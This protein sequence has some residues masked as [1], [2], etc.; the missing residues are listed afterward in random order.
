MPS[1][2]KPWEVAGSATTTSATPASNPAV[3][4]QD[5]S[6]PPQ[7]PDRP[8][9]LTTFANRPT[10]SALG[11]YGAGMSSGYSPYASR[12]GSTLGGYGSTYG[13]YG[14]TYSSP[15]SRFGGG[16]GSTLG[17]YGGMSGYG[18][19]GGMGGGMYGMGGGMYGGMGGIP[20][21]PN[22]PGG[23]ISLT[24]RMESGTAA[25]FQIIESVVGAFGGFAQM[26][27][28]TFMATHSSFFAMIGVAEQFG[29]LRNYLGQILSVFA[30]IRWLKSLFY[31]ATGTTPPAN[32]AE[33][34][35]AEFTQ[36]E[37]RPKLSKKPIL[38]FFAV[39]FGLPWLM[40]KVIQIVSRNQR[41]NQGQGA[42]PPA[43]ANQAMMDLANQKNVDPS[44]LEFAR[45]LYD[46]TAGQEGVELTFRKG[47]I[48]AILTKTDPM[49]QP[50]QW[51]RGR[52]RSGD[53][54]YFPANYVEVLNM[55]QQPRSAPQ[56]PQVQQTPANQPSSI[57]AEEF[58]K[59]M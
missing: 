20:G 12:Y 24:Q 13:G 49:G 34:T 22:A 37:Q 57:D 36:F 51:W 3:P 1:P 28:S 53:V 38:I 45:A 15:Y 9:S 6:L 50:S 25:T 56:A 27:E 46:F 2:P 43:N 30:L 48:I 29:S 16:Y 21:D 5:S 8:S 19:Y 33:L 39:V 14:S 23:P 41:E 44:S 42:L 55:K 7:I 54:G 31:K 4:V 47:E 58:A 35:S 17:G 52:L 18:S 32:A 11:G 10:T 59:R 40:H 26:L